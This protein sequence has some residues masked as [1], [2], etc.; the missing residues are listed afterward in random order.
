MRK[1]LFI[2]CLL[3]STTSQAQIKADTRSP[4]QVDT[5]LNVISNNGPNWILK[6]TAD[7][8][9]LMYALYD[10]V[11][12]DIESHMF[13]KA[14]TTGRTSRKLLTDT[15]NALVIEYKLTFK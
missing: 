8:S 10:S 12:K 14:N 2:V 1:I 4:T 11:G 3:I 15:L 5:T 9:L 6:M 7:N 13:P